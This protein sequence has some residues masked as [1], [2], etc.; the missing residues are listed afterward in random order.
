MRF[1][2]LFCC[3]FLI[4]CGGGNGSDGPVSLNQ[5]TDVSNQISKSNNDDDS[6]NNVSTSQSSIEIIKENRFG[7][8]VF[9]ECKFE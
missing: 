8:C 5:Q 3:L 6:N 9:G 1:L 2:T 7:E 4:S